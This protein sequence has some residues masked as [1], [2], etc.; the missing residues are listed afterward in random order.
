MAEYLVPDYFTD[1]ECKI[2]ACRH[3]CCNGWPISISMK[4]YFRL[5]GMQCNDDLR[6]R[7]DVSL[8]ICENPSEE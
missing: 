7:I 3:V 8:H 4:D 5:I 2:G 6:H 1:F